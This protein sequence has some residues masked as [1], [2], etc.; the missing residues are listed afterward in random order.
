MMC[1]LWRVHWLCAA[2]SGRAFVFMSFRLAA[3]I[4]HNWIRAAAKT[5]VI[6]VND[7][8]LRSCRPA[9]PVM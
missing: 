8:S 7:G 2:K 5:H 1:S 9:V 6:S 3:K 4:E